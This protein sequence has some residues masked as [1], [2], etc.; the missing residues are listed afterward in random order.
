MTLLKEQKR[1]TQ[2]AQSHPKTDD[3]DIG[4]EHETD[5]DVRKNHS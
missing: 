1:E 3:T 2:S 5:E 4:S